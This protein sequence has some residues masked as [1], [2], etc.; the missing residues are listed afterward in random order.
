MKH[1]ISLIL[2]P[3]ILFACDTSKAEDNSEKEA[4]RLSHTEPTV[5]EVGTTPV[6]HGDF[7]MELVSNGQLEARQKAIEP[8]RVQEVFESTS[9]TDQT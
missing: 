1:L 7:S 8:F 6:V 2:L 3:F 9:T 5:T 4:A